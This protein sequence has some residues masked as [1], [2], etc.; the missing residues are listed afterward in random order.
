MIF[1]EVVRDRV[2][3]DSWA[4]NEQHKAQLGLTWGPW[5]LVD[6]LPYESLLP[7]LSSGEKEDWKALKKNS[8][9]EVKE[10]AVHFKKGRLKSRF[11]L[12]GLS[13]S[14]F[15]FH[16]NVLEGKTW[17][18]KQDGD[19]VLF[20]ILEEERLTASTLEGIQ[21]AL[22][23]S[24]SKE[25]PL[26]ISHL[27]KHFCAGE[28]W[29]AMLDV[30]EVKNFKAIDVFMTSSQMLLMA[31]RG[32]E[33]PVGFCVEGLS[34][35]GATSLLNQGHL[36]LLGAHFGSGYD[37]APIGCPPSM[38]ITSS[39]LRDLSIKDSELSWVTGLRH[40]VEQMLS[41]G[42]L[43]G[44]ARFEA[45]PW[46]RCWTVPNRERRWSSASRTLRDMLEDGWSPVP[47]EPQFFSCGAS[48]CSSLDQQ[49]IMMSEM[50]RMDRVQ[51]DLALGLHRVCTGGGLPKGQALPERH[52]WELE[53]ELVLTQLGKVEVRARLKQALSQGMAHG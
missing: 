26:V 49:V 12:D 27:G 35:G 22:E 11:A 24:L 34:L 20:F 10:G 28:D 36:C 32:H 23:A 9:F 16:P 46:A 3:G 25:Q 8:H 14:T 40:R 21:R 7:Y 48:V 2:D 18:L 29:Q 13:P 39:W 47:S 41:G 38:G 17:S 44:G 51:R 43:W 50:G 30:A 1:I 52:L 31:I 33:Q 5:D 37:T 42:I 15:R 45:A 6:Q 19:G 53:R 4:A